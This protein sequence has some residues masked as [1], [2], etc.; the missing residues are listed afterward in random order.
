MQNAKQCGAEGNNPSWDKFEDAMR[1][2]VSVPHAA[3]KA[4][5]DAEKEAK[6]LK[7]TRKSKYAAFRKVNGSTLK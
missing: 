5:L 2:I 6:K 4:H 3:I 1:Q 7:R